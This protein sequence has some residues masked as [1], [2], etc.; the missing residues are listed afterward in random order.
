MTD[1]FQALK[2]KATVDLQQLG[3]PTKQDEAWKYSPATAY[4]SQ[5]FQNTLSSSLKITHPQGVLVQTIARAVIEHEDKIKPYLGQ[6]LKHTSGF[7]AQNTALFNEGVFVY[8]PAGVRVEEPIML[9]YT[10]TESDQA[11]YIRHLIVAEVGSKAVIIEDYQ[12]GA[13]KLYFTNTMTELSVA[14]KAEV[15]HYK[16]QCE[17]HASY[18][19]GELAITQAAGSIF[20][21]HSV[22]FGGQWVR[23][24]TVVSLDG[25]HAHCKLNGIYAPSFEQH[26]DHHTRI[27]HAVP[28]CTSEQDYKGMVSGHARAVFNGQVLVSPGADRT[29]AKQS[30]KNLLLS[31]GA[32][33]DT[34]PE[35]QIFADDVRCSHGATVGQLDETALFYL[36]ARG[37]DP[38]DARR[39]L[40]EA[41][42]TDNLRCMTYEPMAQ[43]VNDLFIDHVKG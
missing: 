18:H 21:G 33:V 37:L 4:V 36:E 40:V 14:E 39:M 32:E 25:P 12:G 9:S 23:S 31:L 17:G 35:L 7:H 5:T 42:V 34:K 11:H 1:W 30:N 24:D 22:A 26:L 29:V 38:V 19:V 16:I 3:F 20:E 28:D 10:Q 27:V 13:D 41:F 15:T 6:I 2:A 43:R 8:I